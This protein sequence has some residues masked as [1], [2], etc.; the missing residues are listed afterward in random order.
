MS[1]VIL[2]GA[3]ITWTICAGQRRMELLLGE[4][5]SDRTGKLVALEIDW[6]EF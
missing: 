4:T 3:A 6:Y 5:G 1:L 2:R